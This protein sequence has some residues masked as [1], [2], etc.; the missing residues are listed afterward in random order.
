LSIQARS[1]VQFDIDIIQGN[2]QFA[3]LIPT[4][5]GQRQAL[6]EFTQVGQ[7][8][9]PGLSYGGALFGLGVRPVVNMLFANVIGRCLGARAY[10]DRAV[11][12]VMDVPNGDLF[13]FGVGSSIIFLFGNESACL[14]AVPTNRCAAGALGHIP[15][16][17]SP[18]ASVYFSDRRI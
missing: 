6:T 3:A 2:T 8:V 14:N 17:L 10:I 4:Q 16:N 7:V 18:A 12:I 9:R 5:G 15:P 1:G 13:G 11:G